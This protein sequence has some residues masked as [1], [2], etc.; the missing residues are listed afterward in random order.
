LLGRRHDRFGQSKRRRHE[1]RSGNPADYLRLRDLCAQ[2]NEANDRDIDNAHLNNAITRNQRAAARIFSDRTRRAGRALGWLL[3][4]RGLRPLQRML[5]TAQTSFPT[6]LAGG[7]RTTF[8]AIE[9]YLGRLGRDAAEVRTHL[10]RS[11]RHLVG[12]GEMASVGR[13]A[14]GVAHE[15]RQSLTALRLRVYSMR[16]FSMA[17]TSSK[18]RN[19]FRGADALE[20]IVRNFLDFSR[21]PELRVRPCSIPLLVSGRWSCSITNRGVAPPPGARGAARH[22]AVMPIRSNCNRSCLIVA[23]QRDRILARRRHDSY[24]GRGGEPP[25]W[26]TG[27]RLGGDTH[28]RLRSGVSARCGTGCSSLSSPQN[29]TALAWVFGSPGAFRCNMAAGS[30]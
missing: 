9:A 15:V 24:R 14:A 18:H 29:R 21:P 27:A 20:N 6:G 7:C 8:R 28:H 25:G 3:V 4:R 12:C 5:G 16:K 2:L 30:I 23:Q 22:P 10:A 1:N 11:E 17:A 26:C 13:I 19:D